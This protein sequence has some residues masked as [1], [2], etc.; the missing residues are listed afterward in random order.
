MAD[1]TLEFYTADGQRL[2][3]SHIRVVLPDGETFKIEADMH[4]H[5]AAT[6]VLDPGT[7][8]APSRRLFSIEP[9]AVNLFFIRAHSYPPEG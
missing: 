3:T 2:D 4:R 1:T 9:G 6:V 8:E 7:P 5:G